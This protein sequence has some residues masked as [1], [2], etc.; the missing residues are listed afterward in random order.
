MNFASGSLRRTAALACLALLALSTLASAAGNLDVFLVKASNDGTTDDALKPY[1]ALLSRSGFK[2][3]TV[4]ARRTTALRAGVVS[5][6]QGF[7][8]TLGNAEGNRVPVTISRDDKNLIRTTL[9]FAPG[10]PVILG[11]YEGND[12]ARMILVLVLVE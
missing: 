7:K 3:Y 6:A 10:R 5:L 1:L 2:S 12:G 4:A 9:N 11:T 8:A